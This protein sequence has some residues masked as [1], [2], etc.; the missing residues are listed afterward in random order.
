ML[1]DIKEAIDAAAPRAAGVQMP[2]DKPA[3]IKGARISRHT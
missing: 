2:P 3:Q 1:M